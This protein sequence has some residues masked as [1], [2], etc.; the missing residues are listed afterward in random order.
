VD[1]LKEGE[2]RKR[3]GGTGGKGSNTTT[4]EVCE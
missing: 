2:E 1:N 3:R 4:R